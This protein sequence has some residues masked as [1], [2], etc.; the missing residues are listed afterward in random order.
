MGEDSHDVGFEAFAAARI[1]SLLRFGFALAGSTVEAED[2]VQEALVRLASRWES[3]TAVG[4]PEPYVRRTMVNLHVSWWRSRRREWLR[5]DPPERVIIDSLPN[6]DLWVALRKLPPRQRAVVALR[7]LEDLT[8]AETAA[9]LGCSVGT[10]KSQ[11]A[12]AITKLRPT[13]DK[14]TLLETS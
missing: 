4:S 14:S 7:Y 8:E 13:L 10:V 12:K 6:R 9:V 11:T 1:P 3:V 2:L 5:A